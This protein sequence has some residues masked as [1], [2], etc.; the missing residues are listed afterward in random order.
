[1]DQ[2][3]DDYLKFADERTR[4]F[5]S[6]PPHDLF[7]LVRQVDALIRDVCAKSDAKSPFPTFLGMNAYY[8][9]M[10]SV[11]TAISGHVSAVFP[12]VRAGL[13][14]ACYAFLVTK[15]AALLSIWTDREMGDKER[16]ACRRAFTSAIK[17]TSDRLRSIQ[18]E[19]ADYL[20]DLYD[21]AI[22]FGAH[23]N[24]SAVMP[25]LGVS[26]D[27]DG[28]HW[29]VTFTC[30]YGEK[31]REVKR[32][33]LACVEYGIMIAYLIT[34][35][36]EKHTDIVEINARFNR[37]NDAKN[38]ITSTLRSDPSTLFDPD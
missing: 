6:A 25:Y 19:V 21:A 22:T 24:A 31:S 16:A 38:S 20:R 26:D 27:L 36:T 8:F 1:M 10:V 14:S 29:R 7:E 9:F 15:D 17:D 32:A 30:M 33:L 34:Y 5:L 37:L 2:T 11:R 18:P 4:G 3:I 28:N 35:L 12:L 23:P 13:E